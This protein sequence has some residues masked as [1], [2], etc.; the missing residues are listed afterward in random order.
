MTLLSDDEVTQLEE[1]GKF[2]II[3][4][5][6]F[7]LV[8]TKEYLKLAP[9]IVGHIGL[10]S[11]YTRRGMVLL[12]GPQIDPGFEG[13]LHVALCNLSP[14]EIS[15]SYDDSFCTVE[16]HKI[17]AVK[18]PYKG[19]YQGQI[20]ITADEIRDIRAGKGMA[21]SESMELLRTTSVITI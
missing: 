19:K 9:S 3:P 15:L 17:P 5:G 8:I 4:A 10:R 21:L 18:R 20:S 1:G 11:K 16:F 7:A 13:N 14:S 6:D 12:A 2:L